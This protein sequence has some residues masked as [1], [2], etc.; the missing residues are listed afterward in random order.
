[1][2][3]DLAARLCYAAPM[4]HDMAEHFYLQ[5]LGCKVNQYEVRALAEAWGRLGLTPAAS[6]DQAGLLVLCSC[7]VTARAEA[8]S[9]RLTRKLVEQAPPGA[10][11]VVT[12]CA[13]VVVPRVF[14]GLGAVPVPDKAAL[15]RD[16]FGAGTGPASAAYP[17]LAVSGH[18]RARALLKIEDGCSHRCAFCIV[19][20]GRGPSRSRPLAGILAEAERLVLAGHGELGLTGIN[21]GHFGRDLDPPMT[22]W[23]LVETLE[24][25]LL[26]RFDASRV[27]LRLGSLDPSIL[28][29]AGVAVLSRSRLVCPHLHISLQSADPGVLAEMGRRSGDAAA[30]SSFVDCMSR[31]W[32]RLGLGLDVMTG[33]PGESEDAFAVTAD[34]L[35][36]LPLTYAHVF[37]FSRRPAT[38]AGV[39]PDQVPRETAIAR[40][41]KLRHVV[42]ERTAGFPDALVAAGAPV[43]VALEGLAP[44]RGTCER[45]LDCRFVTEPGAR[46][47]ALTRGVPVG[48]DGDV[49]LVSP[50]PGDDPA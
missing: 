1:M 12:G 8:E 36:T 5:T 11:V 7:C 27:R 14:A 45:Y 26:A 29:D 41:A 46:I 38:R 17:D 13:A 3:M 49:L 24:D 37:P 19:P 47:G 30:V 18:D 50:A 4:P 39:R 9:R 23:Q 21:L 20:A 33:F 28:N 15:A 32:P 6:P 34:F 22:L 42:A 35:Q 31:V 16:P 2:V 44:A 43:T 10:R 25:F 48:R 40:A